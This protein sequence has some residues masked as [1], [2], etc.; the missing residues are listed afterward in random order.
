L[1]THRP[2][3]LS[4]EEV[5]LTTSPAARDAL[6]AVAAH[7]DAALAATDPAAAL[8]VVRGWDAAGSPDADAQRLRAAGAS[9]DWVALEIPPTSFWDLHVGVL[10]TA[11]EPTRLTVG[12]HWR[13]AVDGAVRPL[14]LELAPAEALH[15]APVSGENQQELPLPPGAPA[16][17]ARAALD[18][19]QHVR[20]VLSAT[21]A[22]TPLDA[23]R[24]DPSISRRDLQ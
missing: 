16:E 19:A 14:A 5:G 20:A 21:S 10:A 4:L 6:E 3:G 18:L 24:S 11:D 13:P 17:R 8:S 9:W 12:L 1:L 7:L 2:I 22:G 15:F 23:P